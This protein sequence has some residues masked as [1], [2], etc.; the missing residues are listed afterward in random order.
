MTE[1]NCFRHIDI[2][3]YDNHDNENKGANYQSSG[4]APSDVML[5]D[6]VMTR[7]R[8]PHYSVTWLLSLCERNPPVTIS[9]D[10]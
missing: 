10:Q 3:N 1:Y 4:L 5:R 6:D 8:F 2:E 7:K 9:K